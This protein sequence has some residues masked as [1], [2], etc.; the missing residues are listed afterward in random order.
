MK[1]TNLKNKLAFNKA[2][3]SELN[4]D[5]MKNVMGGTGP[6]NGVM[7]I[8]DEETN[9]IGGCTPGFPFPVKIKN[10]GGL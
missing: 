5:S 1:K 7:P 2:I 3:V 9:I 4:Q 10:L 6:G 8:Y